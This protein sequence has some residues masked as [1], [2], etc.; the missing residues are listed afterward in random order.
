MSMKLHGAAHFLVNS[1]VQSSSVRRPGRKKT[2][3]MADEHLPLHYVERMFYALTFINLTCPRVQ[4][5]GPPK[6]ERKCSLAF[7]SAS[8]SADM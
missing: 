2:L 5:S 6:C 8:F 7:D 4:F 1:S 3:S